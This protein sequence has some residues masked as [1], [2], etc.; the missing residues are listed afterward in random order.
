MR[1]AVI[2]AGTVGTAVGRAWAARGHKVTWGVRDPARARDVSPCRRLAE[3]AAD[4]EVVLLAV[5]F[6]SAEAALSDCGDLSGKILIDPTNPLAPAEGGL[7]LSMGFDRSAAEFIAARTTARVVKSLNQVGAAVLG[8]TSRYAAPP[9]QFVAGDD[10]AAKTVVASLVGDLGFEVLDAG[11]LKSA[12]LL[13]P[14]AVVWIDQ[15]M[16]Y[17]MEGDRA[18]SLLRRQR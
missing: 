2:G 17:G 10:V 7:V 11:P 12:R 16:R 14:M 13:E 6:H 15:A 8:D 9:V 1:I 4:A 18:W 5:M 3:A